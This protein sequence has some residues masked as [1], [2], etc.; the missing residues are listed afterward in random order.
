[1][2]GPQPIAPKLT[3][4][5]SQGELLLLPENSGDAMQS[6]RTVLVNLLMQGGQ[7]ELYHD[8]GHVLTSTLCRTSVLRGLEETDVAGC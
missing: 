4:S 7:T 6:C 3:L 2:F 1:M 8:P 5:E